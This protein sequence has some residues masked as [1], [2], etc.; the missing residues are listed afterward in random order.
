MVGKD[1]QFINYLL[2]LA[3]F[4]GKGEVFVLNKKVET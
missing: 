3:L 1:K 2:I 4:L